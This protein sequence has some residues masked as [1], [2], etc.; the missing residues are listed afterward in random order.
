[1]QK[2]LID[3]DPGHDDAAA[4]LF[5]ATHLDLVGVTTVYGNQ[6]VDKTTANA[7]SLLTLLGLDIPVARGCDKPLIGEVRH[8]GDLHGKTGIDGA[9][10]PTPDRDAIDVHAVDFIIEMASQ[11]KHE[12]VLCPIGPMTNVGIAL[13]KEPRL[14]KWVRGISMLG[15]T[16][17][18]GNTT[19]VAE[20]NIWSDPEAA[21]II[22]RSGAPLWMTG[23][24]V[25]RQA[26]ISDADIARLAGTG[27]VGDAFSGLFSFFLGRLQEVHGLST[28][29]LHDPCALVPFIC[30]ELITYRN[31]PV[32]I[33]L[34][35]GPTRG[36]TVCDLRNLTTASLENIKGMG[37]RNCQVAVAIEGAAVVERI[38]SAI[39]G[40]SER[41]SLP[42]A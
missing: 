8:G 17:Q 37:V 36:M 41:A 13:R 21:D 24:N 27:P 40:W 12:L 14:A 39:I 28:A 9:E 29:S 32:E 2:I 3:C 22:F 18:I 33:A 42:A 20:F 5:A 7:L 4:I 6:T 31:I 10:L 35:Q 1:M 30:P 16:T 11:Y 38:V 23:L 34:A 25:T 15:G 26:G 19:P